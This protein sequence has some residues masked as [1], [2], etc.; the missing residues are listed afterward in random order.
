MA[1]AELLIHNETVFVISGLKENIAALGFRGGKD[2]LLR[3]S[4]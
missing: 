1:A 3:W 2:C 4:L